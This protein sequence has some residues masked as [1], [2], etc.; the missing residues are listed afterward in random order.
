[1][2]DYDVI[3]IGAGHNGL[4]CAAYLAQAGERV[5]VLE[6]H[7]EAGGCV[8]TACIPGF[9]EV[10]MDIGG[11]EHG[12]FAHS[13]VGEELRLADFG[14]RY[15]TRDHIYSFP[16]A[17]GVS[18]SIH[19]DRAKTL[20]S[21]AALS[22]ADAEAFERFSRFSAP[23]LELLGVVS[24]GPPPSLDQ[25]ATLAGAAGKSGSTLLHTFLSSPRQVVDHWF[26]ND[27]IRAGLL[28][29]AT[30]AQ[31]PPWQLGSG[32]APCLAIG[33]QGSGGTRAEGG[34]R[35]LISAL[36][37]CIEHHGGAVRCS[38]PA[39][40]MLIRDRRA[41]GVELASGERITAG[42]G[43]VSAID[44]RRLFTELVDVDDQPSAF[45]ARMA[46]LTSGRDNIGELSMA[47]I[48]TEE[49]RFASS[50]LGNGAIRGSVW[51]S[52]TVGDV[53][54]AFMDIRRG[55][56][57][58]R[59][60]AMWAAPS[61]LDPSLA[62]EGTHLLWLAA[63]V[64]YHWRDGSDWDQMKERVA[65]QLLATVGTVAPNVSGSVRARQVLSP[66]DWQRR[67]GNLGGHADHLDTGI[68]QMLA[69]R[70]SPDLSRYRTPI[71]GLYLSGAGTHPG[72]GIT[73]GPGR[74][75][76][77][78]YL[79]DRGLLPRPDI[80][81]AGRRLS[82]LGRIALALHGVGRGE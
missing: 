10:R 19:A 18:W 20:A 78:V 76:A 66:L 12:A 25:L 56:M 74:N 1:M 11:L 61:A 57:P 17:D 35:G 82:Q 48:V 29:Y 32:Y 16:F 39:Q 69:N 34:G 40:R 65:D 13:P 52:G 68:D 50:A 63:F 67:T 53:E 62:P 75:T 28:N 15:L 22:P 72:G 31:T 30:H 33:G 55:I 36:V 70:P 59:P 45:R 58:E 80:R 71:R 77:R 8:A 9:P 26:E 6:R 7:H 81:K 41:V 73:G 79:R 60:G 37:R 5:L 21:I 4:V 38:T 42:H 27:Y 14:L 49:P 51:Q 47:C 23:I 24:E 43:V 46:R 3:V 54:N 2:T 64:P 44:A